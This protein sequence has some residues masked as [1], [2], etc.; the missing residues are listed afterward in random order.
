LQAFFEMR[1]SQHKASK[2]SHTL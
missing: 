1:R 2:V